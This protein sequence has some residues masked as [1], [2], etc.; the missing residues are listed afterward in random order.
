MDAT[1]I[2][3]SILMNKDGVCVQN[4]PQATQPDFNKF[5]EQ[6]VKKSTTNR[7]KRGKN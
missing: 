7:L 1:D 6:T 5:V 4:C 3:L 2:I